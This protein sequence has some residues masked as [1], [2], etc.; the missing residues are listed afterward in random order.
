MSRTRRHGWSWAVGAV[1]C[2]TLF[3]ACHFPG[4]R[5]LEDDNHPPK[6]Q[7]P[8]SV[9]QPLPSWLD[10]D[11]SR[12]AGK[13]SPYQDLGQP[14]ALPEKSPAE[15]QIRQA[16]YP[17]VGE[18][19]P[20]EKE[21]K[22][23]AQVPVP[24]PAE[25]G[26]PPGQVINLESKPAASESPLLTALRCFLDKRP[27]EAV[28]LLKKYEEPNQEL[29]LCLL[30]LAARM[31]GPGLKAQEVTA[32]MNQVRS[33]EEHL[34]PHTEL[35][36]DKMVFCDQIKG[37]GVYKPVP[38][39][40]AFRAPMYGRPGELVQLYVE[41]SNLSMKPNGDYYETRL[42]SAVV[43]RP[44][45][46]GKEGWLHDF[47]DRNGVIRSLTLRHDFFNPYSFYVPHIPPGNYNLTIEVVDMTDTT[48]PR[49]ARKTLPFRVTTLSGRDL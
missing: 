4:G 8:Q 30:P 39:G 26:A 37:F 1:L 34:G 14:P 29:L 32:V 40:H 47:K 5:K 3:S 12:F 20:S 49:T 9:L 31:A 44:A 48:H 27:Q 22:K 41:L 24:S 36:I 17:P 25:N 19:N 46:G 2:A 10:A 13:G 11:P 28:A 33:L 15:V 18:S 23:P 38:E 42:S 43:I 7:T 16:I 45:G 6:E 21:G 35:V